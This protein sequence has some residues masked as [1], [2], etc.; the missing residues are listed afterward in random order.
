MAQPDQA[1]HVVAQSV[2]DGAMS[3]GHYIARDARAHGKAGTPSW[4]DQSVPI[5][6]THTPTRGRLCA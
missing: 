3:A 6:F 2:D 5:R 1:I 4:E